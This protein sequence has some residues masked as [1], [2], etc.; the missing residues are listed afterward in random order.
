M[1]AQWIVT[2]VGDNL[3]KLKELTTN[4]III[5][6]LQYLMFRKDLSDPDKNHMFVIGLNSN[7]LVRAKFDGFID[8]F[9]EKLSISD[10]SGPDITKE[11][12]ANKDTDSTLSANSDVK[13]PSQK[14]IKTYVD[15]N[16]S[17]KLN[18]DDERLYTFNII[19]VKKNPGLNEYSSINDALNSITDNDSNNPYLIK[20][21]SGIYL[22]DTINMKP[23]VSVEG[24]GEDVTVI[25][26]NDTNK[27]V[28]VGSDYSSIEH[29][30][31][32]GATGVGYAA[33]YFSSAT[34]TTLTNFEVNRVKFG[35]N[36]ILVK[37]IAPNNPSAVFINSCTIG[38]N[39]QFN[40][41]FI[42]TNTGSGAGRIIIRNSTT[43]GMSL[44]Y[45]NILAMADGDGCEIVMN[46]VQLR[47][48][49]LGGIG[50][51]LTN[52]GRGRLI[53]V[54]LKG[55]NTGILMENVGSAPT[56]IATAINFEE[57]TMDLDVQHPSADGRFSG[58]I[59]RT[60][61]FI[62]PS[63]TVIINTEDRQIIRVAKLDADFSSIFDAVNSITDSSDLKRYVVSVGPG[64]FEEPEI[65]LTNKPYVSVVGNTIQTT[66]VK[67]DANSHHIFKLGAN[68]EISY[69]TLINAG[70]G[71]AGIAVLDIGDYAQAHKVSFD[72]CDTCIKITS[73]TQDTYFYG[74]Y[75][76][77]NG[78]YTYGT[79]I[80]A[81]NG[82]IA[83]ANLENY[84][85]IPST[86]QNPTY[87]PYCTYMT[88]SGADAHILSAGMLGC[89]S[90]TG[91]YVQDGAEVK[92]T[93]V[94]FDN[95]HN[96]IHIGNIGTS[97]K[98]VCT[99]VQTDNSSNYDL[100]AE[101]P[102]S[103]GGYLGSLDM[104]KVSI[105]SNVTD[106]NICIQN[107]VDGSLNISNK[108]NIRFADSTITDIST[109]VFE[110]STMGLMSGGILSDGG[111][112]SVDVSAGF[113]YL[114]IFP[115]NNTIKKIE[116]SNTS[117]AIPANST[118]YIYFNQNGILSANASFPDSIYNIVLGRVVSGASTIELID[119]SPV[120]AQHF[121]NNFSKVLRSA[122]GPVY[123]NGSLV[124]ENVTPFHLDISSGTYAFSENIFNP[125]GGTN[126]NFTTYYRDGSGGHIKTLTNVVDNSNYDDGSGTL[127]SLTSS[128]YVKH[129]YYLIGQGVNEKYLLVYGQEEFSSLV[130]AEQGN[131]PLA[132][133]YF[134]DGVVLIASII[135]QQGAANVTSIQDLRP[136]LG[137]RA[138]SVSS[139]SFHGNLL[140]LNNDDHPQYLKTD[141]SRTY[142]G[143][144]NFGGNSITNIGQINGVTV[145]T[146][147]TRH[148]PNGSDALTTAAPT[149]NLGA[150]STN[151]IGIQ[152]SF[153]RSDHSHAIDVAN[154]SQG[155][156]LSSTDWNTFNNKQDALG[157]TA[158][159]VS[160]K[161]IDGTLAANSDTKYASQKATKTYVDTGLATK[162]NSLG[163][164][165]E[166][167]E[168]KDVDGTLA[169]NSDTKYTSQRAIKTY[170]DTKD[171]NNIKKDGSVAFTADQSMGS[172]KLT[173]VTD[174]TAAQDAATKNYV[175]SAVSGGTIARGQIGYVDNATTLT[176][177]ASSQLIPGTYVLLSGGTNFAMTTNGKLKYT[178]ASTIALEIKVVFSASVLTSKLS[179]VAIYKND[180]EVSA[181]RKRQTLYTSDETCALTLQDYS[182]A[183]NDEFDVR[184]KRITATNTTMTSD[185]ITVSAI[186]I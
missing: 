123:A 175:D 26:V 31:L 91:I 56:I 148:L 14:A 52:G 112:L 124:T 34:A 129:S 157:Y 183:T 73:A 23:Y 140:G 9:L 17:L 144:Q 116:W 113:G 90:G 150:S 27:N 155:G 134:D 178:G 32:T 66:V 131:V 51:K 63:S 58:I 60:T 10:G 109:L 102:S 87:L 41:G 142:T 85:N 168:N 46:S 158:E 62:H 161:D 61:S 152:N 154:G 136:I 43:I 185:F 149:A 89:G 128:Y 37:V 79:Y 81:T 125:T 115:D 70:I 141:G 47:V 7:F 104:S 151:S 159:N 167:T 98:V 164:T 65:D 88:G 28:I 107:S 15:D 96:G 156:I 101:H 163:Y 181:S 30:T 92:I 72:N 122:F 69:L 25:T 80:E 53:G 111:L 130:L 1:A 5:M 16:L 21:G 45:P 166:N 99:G 40:Y 82:F 33:V 93:G 78:V 49:T 138:P 179:E 2:S 11:D 110:S 118:R 121:S 29:L 170:V 135:V 184:I 176:L 77:Y 75:I 67:P 55:F 13:Y 71:Y 94:H 173:N 24:S 54:N 20:V 35:E 165:A 177:T 146:H 84:Y 139:T 105:D 137:F 76:D 12:V 22:E 86:I 4:K 169:A 19:N 3:I 6:P 106:F 147:V 50:V 18:S 153:S 145:E 162:Q 119:I 103:N 174:P 143:N 36:D 95:W 68:N 133:S 74:E 100:L 44:P 39:N 117:I 83:F 186:K 126:L 64:I 160:N 180:V 97:S 132:P 120:K 182:V 8:D 171:A 48:P 59:D 172:H 42:A 108:L 114:E 127:A 57:C 38:S